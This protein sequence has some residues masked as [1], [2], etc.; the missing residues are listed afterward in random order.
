M[1]PCLHQGNIYI[2]RKLQVWRDQIRIPLGGAQTPLTCVGRQ[3]TP[4]QGSRHRPENGNLRKLGSTYRHGTVIAPRQYLYEK[5]D[6]GMERPEMSC[7]SRWKISFYLCWTSNYPSQGSQ[8]KAET[9]NLRKFG[10]TYR[11]G[12]VFPQR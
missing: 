4:S 5:E 12:T 8:Y 2:K 6:K 1:V 3:T 7:S 11:R 10:W 9:G